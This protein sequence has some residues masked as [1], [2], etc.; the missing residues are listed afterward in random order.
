MAGAG[1]SAISEANVATSTTAKTVIGVKG[2][3]NFG[4]DF[5]G[6]DIGFNGVTATDGPAVVELGYCTFA[7]NS[8]GTASTSATVRQE[9]GRVIAAG[10]TAA[11]TWTTEPTVITVNRVF[12]VDPNKGLF[13]FD[14]PLGSTPDS[15]VSEGFVLRVTAATGTPNLRAAMR[16][17]RC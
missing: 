7:T 9:Y 14:F 5:T 4:I 12:L 13:S 15:A 6:F 8:P 3:A 2:H 1:Y 17:E 11:Y 10:A 16:W